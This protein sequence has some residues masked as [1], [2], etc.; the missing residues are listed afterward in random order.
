MKKT[1]Y[2]LITFET[3]CWG[4]G[5]SIHNSIEE[6][7]E[8][9]ME[10]LKKEWGLYRKRPFPTKDEIYLGKCQDIFYNE[11]NEYMSFQAGEYCDSYST[12]EIHEIEI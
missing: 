8:A 10:W 9:Q 4:F 11:D 7:R 1:I 12:I 6:A 5:S 3:E 2:V